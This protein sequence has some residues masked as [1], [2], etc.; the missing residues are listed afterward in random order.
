MVTTLNENRLMFRSLNLISEYIKHILNM[1]N[2]VEF[3]LAQQ[4]QKRARHISQT[5][6]T[7]EAC[8]ILAKCVA[9]VL[10]DGLAV[11]A[12]VFEKGQQ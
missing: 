11:D 12:L 9:V 5:L 6:V 3:V 10:C 7:V 1:V 4:L 8:H 2:R